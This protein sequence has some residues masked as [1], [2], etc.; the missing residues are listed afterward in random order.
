MRNIEYYV[1]HMTKV[2]IVSVFHRL[3]ELRVLIELRGIAASPGPPIHLISIFDT[4]N[5]FDI[6]IG[7]LIFDI[8]HVMFDILY[9]GFDI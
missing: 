3:Q 8:E 7:S 1:G 9:L 2:R 4:P 6:N 5:A